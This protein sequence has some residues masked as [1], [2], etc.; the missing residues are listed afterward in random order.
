MSPR[1]LVTVLIG[2]APAAALADR[3]QAAAGGDGDD[4]ALAAGAH[5]AG[6]PSNGRASSS[7]SGRVPGAGGA[8]RR[9][10]ARQVRLGG[11]SRQQQQPQQQQARGSPFLA[12]NSRPP[13]EP[14]QQQQQM[15]VQQG[16]LVRSASDSLCLA[17][18]K[19]Q[20]QEQDWQDEKAA[21][22][23]EGMMGP[24]GGLQGTAAHGECAAPGG[25]VSPLLELTPERPSEFLGMVVDDTISCCGM[26]CKHHCA[27]SHYAWVVN[28]VGA[29]VAAAL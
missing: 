13:A 24:A 9:L 26:G 4:C 27:A 28:G 21:A 7:G 14:Q 1:A 3:A 29:S 16:G 22:E 8:W 23:E 25:K 5:S 12:S 10:V 2:V 18:E 17:L 6:S 15:Q 19:E 11:G 20:E